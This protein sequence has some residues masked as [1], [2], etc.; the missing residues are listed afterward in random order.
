MQKRIAETIPGTATETISKLA[1]LYNVYIVFGL[2]ETKDDKLYN[3]QVLLNP[4]GEIEA[5]H[6]KVHLIDW[7]V[8]SGFTPDNRETVVEIDGIK[9]GMIICADVQSLNQTKVHFY[10]LV[11]YLSIGY[12]IET[13]PLF[14]DF[15]INQTITIYSWSSLPHT[16]AGAD[17]FFSPWSSFV[18]VLP[19]ITFTVGWELF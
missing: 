12:W 19:T 18:P 3:S 7:D 14:F 2:A 6:R 10:N 4:D 11:P 1:K 5:V 9:A 13:K 15:K 8:A 17:W 16:S